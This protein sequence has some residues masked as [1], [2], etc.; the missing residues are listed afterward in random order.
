MTRDETLFVL[1][2]AAVIGLAAL[3]VVLGWA[4]VLLGGVR[5]IVV[6][7]MAGLYALGVALSAVRMRQFRRGV[8]Q[9]HAAHQID[10]IETIGLLIPLVGLAGT[11]GGLIIGTSGV[12]ADSLANGSGQMV[13]SFIGGLSIALWATLMGTVLNA[14]LMVGTRFVSNVAHNHA[15]I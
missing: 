4:D 6:A 8:T 5:E 10:G 15:V 2:H 7:I 3:A 1:W 13:A 14:V 11:V 12:T 9:W